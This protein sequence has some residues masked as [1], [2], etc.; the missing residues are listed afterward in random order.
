MHDVCQKLMKYTGISSFSLP[1]AANIS[2]LHLQYV[3]SKLKLGSGLRFFVPNV[4]ACGYVSSTYVQ[5][6]VLPQNRQA[7]KRRILLA[8]NYTMLDCN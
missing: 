5:F 1:G 4:Q 3:T 7:E 8:S 2:S 6:I